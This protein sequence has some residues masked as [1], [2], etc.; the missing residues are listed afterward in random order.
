MKVY[1]AI[2][3]NWNN[4]YISIFSTKAKAKNFLKKC[5]YDTDSTNII[6]Y[7]LDSEEEI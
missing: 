3:D 7:E 5:K 6:E 2:K 4:D 1:I